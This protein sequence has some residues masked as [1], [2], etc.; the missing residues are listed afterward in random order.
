MKIRRICALFFSLLIVLNLTAVSFAAA[1]AP[2]GDEPEEAGEPVVAEPEEP[3][4]FH[5]AAKAALLVDPD[6]EEVLYEQDAHEILY[7]ASVTKI[8]TCLLALE[9]IDSG[10]LSKNTV[11]M[12]R[13]AVADV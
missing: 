4:G 12:A 13:H 9:A 1:A 11:L 8:M 5:I 6:T 7:P 10:K 2:E 3:E